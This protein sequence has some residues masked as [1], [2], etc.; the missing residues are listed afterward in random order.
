[1]FTHAPQSLERERVCGQCIQ[2]FTPS[3]DHQAA[4]VLPVQSNSRRPT[5]SHREE[6]RRMRIEQRPA[7]DVGQSTANGFLWLL[8]QSLSSRAASFLSQLIL[9]RLLAP[10]AFGQIG[11]AYTVTTLIGALVSFGTD[12]I[13]LQRLRT[14][15]MWVMPAFWSSLGLSVIGMVL[16]LLGAPLAATLYGSPGLT[17]LI[18]LLAISLPIGALATV[19]G[20]KLRADMNFR[21]LATYAAAETICIQIASV[22]LAAAGCGTYSFIIPVPVAAAVKAAVF[23]SKAPARIR[24]RGRLTQ[25]RHIVNSG[26]LV[27]GARMLVTAVNQGDYIVLGLMANDAVV[28][29]YFFAFRLAAQP[30]QMLAGNFGSVIFPALTQLRTDPAR[31]EAAALR[32]SRILV[33]TV[34]PVCFLQAA[35]AAPVLHVMFGQRWDGSIPLM[36]ILSLGLPGDAVAWIAGSLLVARRAFR[37]DFLYLL[38]FCPPFFVMVAVGAYLGSSTGVAIAV[39]LYYALIK[40]VNSWLVF[41]SSMGLR[42]VLQIYINPSILAGLAFGAAYALAQTAPLARHPILQIAAIAATGPL[43]YLALLRLL[44]PAI[45]TEVLQRF[46]LGRRLRHLLQYFTR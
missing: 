34:T 5:P 28:G 43:L 16:M 26:V 13:L 2:S 36:Q 39:S 29:V 4:A 8:L 38:A 12:D 7:L 45:L 25:F 10:E 41:R 30:L 6:L 15:D 11:L 3:F 44:V 24:R 17:G 18:A 42:E 37:L 31:Q 22:I 14:I 23:W 1:M 33:Y 32:A 46:P 20:V 35:V 9:A 19:P 21:Y 27:F 40:P